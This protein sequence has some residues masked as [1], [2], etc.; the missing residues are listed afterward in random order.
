MSSLY[1]TY[2]VC[3]MQYAVLCLGAHDQLS[4]NSALYHTQ[5]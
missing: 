1:I 3:L 2:L 4:V 5:K